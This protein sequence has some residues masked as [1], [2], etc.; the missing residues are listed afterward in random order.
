MKYSAC[1]SSHFNLVLKQ[2]TNLSQTSPRKKKF[3]SE[4]SSQD[5]TRKQNEQPEEQERDNNYVTLPRNKKPLIH[6]MHNM[7]D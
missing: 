7:H 4:A 3:S 6:N 5:G 1:N 2:R